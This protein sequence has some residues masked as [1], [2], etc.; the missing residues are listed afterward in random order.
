MSSSPNSSSESSSTTKFFLLSFCGA[1]DTV[2]AG[3]LVFR[4]YWVMAVSK[5]SS[6]SSP[7]PRPNS[8]SLSANIWPFFSP[9]A[10]PR[11]C[12][13]CCPESTGTFRDGCSEFPSRPG[14]VNPVDSTAASSNSSSISSPNS[15]ESDGSASS[16]GPASVSAS[17]VLD[18]DVPALSWMGARRCKGEPGA[19]SPN[20]TA[21]GS[22][23]E[24]EGPASE[25]WVGCS[26][27]LF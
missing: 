17:M 3:L 20:P 12:C 10:E 6:K 25:L 16:F 18:W 9:S 4:S 13:S 14:T 15:D 24:L 22:G 19:S 8:S 2:C 27:R 26:A 23:D 5:S 7:S 21:P 1:V 11:G